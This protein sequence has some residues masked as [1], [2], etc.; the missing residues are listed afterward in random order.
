MNRPWIHRAFTRQV[1]ILLTN[2]TPMLSVEEMRALI[3]SV[4]ETI[5]EE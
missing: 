4:L 2:F 5:P 1:A 3:E